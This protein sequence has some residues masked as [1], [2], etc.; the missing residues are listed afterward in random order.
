MEALK[1]VVTSEGIKET[2][3]KLKELSISAKDA[4]Q[5]VSDLN[6]KVGSG[7]ESITKF[8]GKTTK[9]S[10]FFS[11]LDNA[12]GGSAAKMLEQE[13]AATKLI[14]KLEQM[15]TAVKNLKANK[16]NYT[17]SVRENSKAID[18]ATESHS[19]NARAVRDNGYG[20]NIYNNTLR[21]M[22]TAALAY[23]GVNFFTS[24]IKEADAWTMMNAK[25]SLVTGSTERATR[26]QEDLFNSAQRLR[27]PVTELATVYARLAPAMERA[28]KGAGDTM[29]VVE[30]LSMALKLGGASAAEASSTML[31]FSQAM[32]SGVLNGG[33]FN[34]IAE[35]IPVVAAA[36]AV[37]ATYAS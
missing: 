11:A 2:S 30:A 31:Q 27:V 18:D 14:A 15:D 29:K 22:T 20:H 23:V 12:I 33:E 19:K 9:M 1:V 17:L 34:S 4:A 35:N 21:A 26:V 3:D 32:N 5:K 7:G 36:V 10:A 6:V 16:G 24:I 8:L 37:V 25:L 28:G 13:T